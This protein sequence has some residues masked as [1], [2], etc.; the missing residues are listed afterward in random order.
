MSAPSIDQII[1][2]L[3]RFSPSSA[4]ALEDKLADDFTERAG[5]HALIQR[6]A[7]LLTGVANALKGQPPELCMHDHSQLPL[8]AASKMAVLSQV[9]DVLNDAA[10][11][12]AKAT[13]TGRV[14]ALTSIG[15]AAELV[16]GALT[17]P[18]WGE[19]L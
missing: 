6:Q 8:V 15:V 5:Q 2:T 18:V 13:T 4:K 9:L 3:R 1:E 7:D 10:R 17:H 11:A 14:E 16:E 19:D 12:L